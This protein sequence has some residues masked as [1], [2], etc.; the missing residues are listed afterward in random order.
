AHALQKK[1][2][3]T[4]N[5]TADTYDSGPPRRQNHGGKFSDATKEVVKE[6]TETDA[7][8]EADPE[9]N[10]DA[11]NFPKGANQTDSSVKSLQETL[12]RSA[13]QKEERKRST[14]CALTQSDGSSESTRTTKNDS[15]GNSAGTTLTPSDD[16]GKYNDNQMQLQKNI[17]V[18]NADFKPGDFT[19]IKIWKTFVQGKFVRFQ[20]KITMPNKPMVDCVGILPD[21]LRPQD[22]P[23]WI[24]RQCSGRVKFATYTTGGHSVYVENLVKAQYTDV[25]GDDIPMTVWNYALIEGCSRCAGKLFDWERPYTAVRHRADVQPSV[26]VNRMRCVC[27]DC[28]MKELP[29]GEIYDRYSKQYFEA[30][31]KHAARCNAEGRSPAHRNPA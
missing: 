17:I 21:G 19:L 10:L 28:L 8:A 9:D 12:T 5:G 26:P 24:E 27:P 13:K 20:G 3:G 23:E 2:S 11:I 4:T 31:Q 29:S 30:K 15:K 1:D 18:A 6:T 25:Y 22:W 7:S 16:V 14:S